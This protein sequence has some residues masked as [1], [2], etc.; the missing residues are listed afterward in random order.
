MVP[1]INPHSRLE[2]LYEAILFTLV[3]LKLDPKLEAY[4]PVFEQILAEWWDVFKAERSI[5]DEAVTA[6][7]AVSSADQALDRTSD[8]VAGTVLIDVGNNRRSPLYT[9]YFPA[10]SPSRF[11]K[12]K[13]SE[14][15]AAMRTW[16][17]SLLDSPNPTLKAYGA[18]LVTQ[19]EA[20]DAAVAMVST[21]AQKLA[22]F[23]TTGA[24]KQLF[25]KVNGARKKLHG[26]AAKLSH[27]HPEWNLTNGYA[28]ALFQHES[29]PPEPSLAEIERK[30]EA[31]SAE[32]TKLTQMREA[33][34]KEEEEAANARKEAEKKA[35]QAELEAAAKVAAE[36]NARFEALQAKLS[37]ANA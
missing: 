11:K 19:I 25:D 33:R 36:A 20:A 22:D 10:E 29:S 21:A 35:Q 24:R 34:I 28:N 31:V 9:R 3:R 18:A 32:L 8:G 13:L 5:L 30:I 16:P 4:V 14:Q 7:A 1:T 12:P 37:V 15:L 26:E 2:T 23:R 17:P 6:D 27:D